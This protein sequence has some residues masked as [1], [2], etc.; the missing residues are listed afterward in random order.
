MLLDNFFKITALADENAI[1]SAALEI[2]AAHPVFAGHF[3]G[4]PVVPGVCM[5][6]MVKEIVE[7]VLKANTL[8][9]KAQDI[10]FMAVID[11]VQNNRINATIQYACSPEGLV[12]IN[13][14]FFKDSLVHFKFKG[15]LQ[16]Q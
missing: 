15:V 9:V 4:Q 10:K 13:A 11:P 16:A 5:M 14:S 3:P 7:S 2:D 12:Q 8:L 1:I 6:Q